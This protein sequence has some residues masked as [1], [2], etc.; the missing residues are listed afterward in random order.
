MKRELII[1]LGAL[2]L[3]AAPAATPVQAGG[4]PVHWVDE[5]ESFCSNLDG[6]PFADYDDC[7][8]LDPFRLIGCVCWDPEE[9]TGGWS[10]EGMGGLPCSQ[11]C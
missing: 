9:G 2:Y 5:C 10:C 11:C 1:G 6:G 3:L 7:Y 4:C 8:G